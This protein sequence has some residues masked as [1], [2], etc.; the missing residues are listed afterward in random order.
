MRSHVQNGTRKVG[1]VRTSAHFESAR[2]I[3]LTTWAS[4]KK[5]SDGGTGYVTKMPVPNAATPKNLRRAIAYAAMVP[6]ATEITVDSTVTR[7]LF[8]VQMGHSVSQMSVV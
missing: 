6:T 4:G 3:Q 2:P 7:R 8:L 1:Y 5:S